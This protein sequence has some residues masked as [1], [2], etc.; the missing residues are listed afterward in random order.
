MDKVLGLEQEPRAGIVFL[1]E[2]R[3]SGAGRRYVTLRLDSSTVVPWDD[4]REMRSLVV[5]AREFC[6]AKTGSEK[7]QR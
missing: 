7:R 4:F 1:Y 6:K 3:F 2:V 5:Q